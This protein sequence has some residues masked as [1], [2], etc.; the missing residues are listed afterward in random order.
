M[1][2]AWPGNVRELENCIERGVALTCFD[3]LVVDDLPERIRD[4]ARRDVLVAS[5]NPCELVTLEEVERRYARRVLEAVGG[6]KARAAR[7]LGV[8]RK[9]LYRKLGE[10]E[11]WGKASVRHG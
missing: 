5:D 6:N 10:A 3:K 4:H 8:D 11:G 7:I 1:N 9:T 2:F